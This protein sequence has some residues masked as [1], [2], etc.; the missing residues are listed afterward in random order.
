[1]QIQAT[2]DKF[3]TMRAILMRCETLSDAARVTEQIAQESGGGVIF[4]TLH[5][6]KGLEAERVF[7][8]HPE[9]IPHPMAKRKDEIEQEMNALYVGL[10]RSK[11][12]LVLVS[13]TN[14]E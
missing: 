5:R 8:L 4:S 10:T 2:G 1:M 9:D 11:R 12:E 6:A 7:F 3:E 13:R 14:A